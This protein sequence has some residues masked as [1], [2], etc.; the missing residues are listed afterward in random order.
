MDVP[1]G[2]LGSYSERATAIV[3]ASSSPSSFRVIC[4]VSEAQV[5]LGNR[6]MPAFGQKPASADRGD[7]SEDL[8]RRSL[9]ISRNG[10]FR[11][12]RRRVA[13]VSNGRGE[14]LF[15][16]RLLKHD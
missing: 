10:W 3:L 14:V 12:D 9:T 4:V 2:R 7:A 13:C 6:A 15:T 5:R 16:K 8:Q 1:G 11:I